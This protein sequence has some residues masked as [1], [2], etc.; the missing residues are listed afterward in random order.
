MKVPVAPYSYQHLISSFF[1][2]AILSYSD[3]YTVA[4]YCSFKFHFF[5]D[6]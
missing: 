1:I 6:K 3:E 5:E 4:M 2:L